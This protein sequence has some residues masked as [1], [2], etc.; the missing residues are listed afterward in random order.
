MIYENVCEIYYNNIKGSDGE[1]LTQQM[2]FFLAAFIE[3]KVHR[4]RRRL[5]TQ[6]I[7]ALS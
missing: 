5:V 4:A 1:S 6:L 3:L 2:G 7:P